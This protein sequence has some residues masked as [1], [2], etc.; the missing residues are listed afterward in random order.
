MH[1]D[2]T[3]TKAYEAELWLNLYKE[4]RKLGN[5]VASLNALNH[6]EHLL[7]Q[8]LHHE[9]AKWFWKEGEALKA[10]KHLASHNKRGWNP[11]VSFDQCVLKPCIYY[12]VGRLIDAGHCFGETQY[13][14]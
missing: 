7:G 10:A 14:P 13:F 1:R 3:L 5:M 12:Y 4:N 11:Q 2:S 6:A 8:E 9:K